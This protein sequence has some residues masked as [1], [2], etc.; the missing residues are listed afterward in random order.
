MT[1]EAVAGQNGLYIL[2]EVK[3]LR[4]LGYAW[5]RLLVAATCGNR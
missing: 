4:G 5:I 2:I 1:T 3:V